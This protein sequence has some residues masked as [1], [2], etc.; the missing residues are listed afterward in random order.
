ME[1]HA[2]GK[3][4]IK[5]SHVRYTGTGSAGEVLDIK[6]DDEGTWAKIDTTDLWYNSEF[7]EPINPREYER[8]KL[9]NQRRKEVS[10]KDDEQETTKSKDDIAKAVNSKKKLEDVDMSNELCDGG[11]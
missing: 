4:I 3:S 6:S 7:L 9:R 8:L 2:Q 11:G 1:V 5:G 10:A